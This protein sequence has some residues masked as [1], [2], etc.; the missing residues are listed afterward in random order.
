MNVLFATP[1]FAPI[2]KAGGLG[3]VSAALP[4]ALARLGAD[5][6][7]LLPGYAGT[8]AAAGQTRVV[9]R[10]A[11]APGLPAALLREAP[12]ADGLRLWLIDAPALYARD[13]GPYADT[14]GR[15]WPDNAQRFA[16]LARTAAEL[17]SARSPLAWRP[18]VV[19]CNDWQAALAAAFLHF[20]GAR[21]AAALLTIHNLAFQGNFDA[22][23]VTQLGLPASCY[24][25]E[26]VEFYGRFSFLK[27]GIVYADALTTVS[28]TYA[29]E[30]QTAAFGCGLD[31]LLRKR[32]ADLHGL[33]NGI[34]TELWNPATDPLIARNYDSETLDAKLENKR[35]LCERF[36][37]PFAPDAPLVGAIG[38][39]TEQKGFDLLI[40]AA[41][42]LVAA[43]ASLVV[44]G[45]GDAAL[46]AALV[47][48]ARRLPRRVSVAIGYDERLAHA[49]EAGADAFVMPSRF[50]PCGMNQMYSQ[51]Y[52]TPPIVRATGGLADTVVDCTPEALAA[53]TASGFVFAGADVESLAAAL[54]RA[55]ATFADRATWRRLQR[56]GMRKD[57]SW[58][59]SARGYLRLYEQ[60]AAAR[61]K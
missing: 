4:R 57:F 18:D 8:L 12:L 53:G 60:I 25:S 43:A 24:T 20:D 54:R 48:L 11:P 45:R 13:G 38:R 37:L 30:I 10:L 14:A 52:G 47:E 21:Q 3:D 23:L 61:G 28:P 17:G 51:V 44:L 7:V 6:R 58:N 33:L 56:N 29:R 31:G 36:G 49:I 35:A 9:A 50:E 15:D 1:E 41:P 46:E 59:A 26:G 5:V 22:A 55:C 27:A 16:L 2:A 39:L 34:D 40:A 19:H 32:S 42:A